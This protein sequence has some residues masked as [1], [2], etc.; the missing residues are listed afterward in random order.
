MRF[1]FDILLSYWTDFSM[2]KLKIFKI[3]ILN[4]NIIVLITCTKK[5][6]GIWIW[7][8]IHAMLQIKLTSRC[9]PVQLRRIAIS[10]VYSFPRSPPLIRILQN[11]FKR[12]SE[13]EFIG[14]R[15][16][17]LAFIILVRINRTISC[18]S[19]LRGDQ[20]FEVQC[21][22]VLR[23]RWFMCGTVTGSAAVRQLSCFC[24]R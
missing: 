8:I 19:T 11:S 16:I 20:S 9:L 5:V 14:T 17:I 18:F 23:T 22:R 24:C 1:Y 15:K 21:C 13:N 7:H 12:L 6:T 3:S 2:S 10:C 4:N